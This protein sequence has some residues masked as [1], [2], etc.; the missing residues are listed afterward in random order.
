MY[1]GVRSPTLIRTTVDDHTV[2]SGPNLASTTA[3]PQAEHAGLCVGITWSQASHLTPMR[4]GGSVP[5]MRG[6]GSDMVLSYAL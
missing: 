4:R 6:L 5:S 1:G 3:P 2:P